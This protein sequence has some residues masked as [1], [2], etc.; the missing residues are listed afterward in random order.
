MRSS[1]GTETAIKLSHTQHIRLPAPYGTCTD[2][3][4]VDVDEVY[5][6]DRGISL[7]VQQHTYVDRCGCFTGSNAVNSTQLKQT[8]Y[9]NCKKQSFLEPDAWNNIEIFADFATRFTCSVDGTHDNCDCQISC[10]EKIYGTV[11]SSYTLPKIFKK[12]IYYNSAIQI[13]IDNN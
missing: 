1:I 12:I 3:K 2:R 5:T 10:N 11:S 6:L 8:N 13:Q 7:C 9:T 4:W